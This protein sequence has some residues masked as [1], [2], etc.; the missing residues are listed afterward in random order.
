[1]LRCRGIGSI[2]TVPRT[3][4]GPPSLAGSLVPPEGGTEEGRGRRS[5]ADSLVLPEDGTEEVRGPPRSGLACPPEG[6]TEE[7]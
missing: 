1:K 6:G 4:P 5:L 3:L 2:V 7:D